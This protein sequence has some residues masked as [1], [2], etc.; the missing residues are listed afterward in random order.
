MTKYIFTLIFFTSIFTPIFA[1]TAFA[2]YYATHC[3]NAYGTIQWRTGHNDNMLVKKENGEDKTISVNQLKI[4]F[5]NEVV[6]KEVTHQDCKVSPI[7]SYTKTWAATVLITPAQPMPETEVTFNKLIQDE[8]I[9][10]MDRNSRM[11]CPE[12]R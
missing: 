8:V 10:R 1:P 4:E 7:Y 6:L 5:Q 9:C 12:D 11:Y 2:S 3:S